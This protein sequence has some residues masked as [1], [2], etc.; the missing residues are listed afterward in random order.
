M[1]KS[2]HLFEPQVRVFLC[3]CNI[4]GPLRK[5][6]THPRTSEDSPTVAAP[7]RE[8]RSLPSELRDYAERI[9]D[10]PHAGSGRIRIFAAAENSARIASA[11][12]R[13]PAP[14]IA[15]ASVALRGAREAVNSGRSVWAS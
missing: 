14:P 15:P 9:S 5:S 2:W 1:I 10:G 11:A 13:L 8:L 12:S 7:V 6:R 3:V 4:S